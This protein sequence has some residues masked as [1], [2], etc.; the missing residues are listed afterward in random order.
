MLCLSGAKKRKK[1]TNNIR[2]SHAA[3]FS[4]LTTY[5]P[6]GLRPREDQAQA[7]EGQDGHLEYYIPRTALRCEY[8]TAERWCRYLRR[9]PLID[10]FCFYSHHPFEMGF[11]TDRYCGKCGLTYTFTA[12]SKPPA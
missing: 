2:F 10:N 9:F 8:P 7:Q 12:D 3:V 5:P 4:M 11:H 6:S 1:K